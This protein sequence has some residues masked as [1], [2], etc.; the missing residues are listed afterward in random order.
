MLRIPRPFQLKRGHSK[1]RRPDLKQ[2]VYSL[3]VTNDGAAPVHFKAY[4]GNQTDDAIHL[5]T[6]TGCALCCSIR[7]SF[8]S[9]TASCAQRRTC[10]RST[11]NVG[12]LSPLF[13]RTV[14]KWQPLA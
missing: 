4:D 8:T 1:E 14:P 10:A 3:C 9:Q 5:E 7:T 2:L 13:P 11:A 12:S 6:W